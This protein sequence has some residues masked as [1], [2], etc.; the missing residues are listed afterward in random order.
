MLMRCD[1]KNYGEGKRRVEGSRKRKEWK[2]G[3]YY[4]LREREFRIGK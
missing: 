2:E 4:E 3:K 1:V